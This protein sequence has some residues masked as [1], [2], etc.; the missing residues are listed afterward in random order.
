M[1]HSYIGKR[2]SASASL[3]LDF[4]HVFGLSSSA[5]ASGEEQHKAFGSGFE[6]RPREGHAYERS[7]DCDI[8]FLSETKL[9]RQE[10]TFR[11]KSENHFSKA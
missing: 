5:A 10:E 9:K 4:W 8:I 11:R 7:D 1:E 2:L 3:W 6:D